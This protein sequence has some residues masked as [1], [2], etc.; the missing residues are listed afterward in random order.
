M[1]QSYV[2]PRYK[3]T[4][5]ESDKPSKQ[6]EKLDQLTTVLMSDLIVISLKEN[7]KKGGWDGD[8]QAREVFCTMNWMM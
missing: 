8:G 6:C 7:G 5:E 3:R 2:G 1:S 4:K